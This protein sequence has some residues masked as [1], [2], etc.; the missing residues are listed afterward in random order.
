MDW[1]FQLISIYITVCEAWKKGI[2]GVVQRFSNHSLFALTDEEVVCIY[3]FGILSGCT[4]VKGV[5][6]YTDRHLRD[7]FPTLGGYA[8]FCYRLNKISGGFTA[9]C[10]EIVKSKENRLAVNWVT[11]SFPIIL[12]GS[13]RSGYA[14]VAPELA[15]KGFCASKDLYF[16]GVKLHCVGE[17]QPQTI[18]LPSFIGVAPASTNDN[19]MF[20][21]ISSELHNCKIFGDKAY[22]DS[23]HRTH[24]AKNQDVQ[25]L[26]PT[27]KIKGGFGFAGPDYFSTWVSAIRQ[28]IESL[29]NWL[30]EKTKIQNASKVRSSAGLIVHIFGRITAA[31][32]LMTNFNL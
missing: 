7:W 11:D 24:L 16:Y 9:L 21:Q 19:R 28:P 14:K 8:A 23:E 15:D 20:E 3:L 31:L 2:C 18:P 27:K 25:L 5:Y 17:L 1:Q 4:T 10:S 26:T 13:R 6:D 30:Q 12:A 32:L 22:A 29:F